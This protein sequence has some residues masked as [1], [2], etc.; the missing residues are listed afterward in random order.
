MTQL[1]GTAI[2]WCIFAAFVSHHLRAHVHVEA[3]ATHLEAPEEQ[4]GEEGT[5]DTP[6][7]WCGSHHSTINPDDVPIVGTMPPESEAKGTTGGDLIS[8]RTASVDKKP[9][10]TN[11]VDDY[12]QGEID[13]RWKPIRIRAYTQDL[14]DP[15]R[16][17]TMAGDVR[18]ILVSGKTTVCTAGDVLTVRKK[19]VIVQVAIPKAI[20]LHTDRLLVRR[21]HRRIVLPSSYA[22]Y[23]SLFK[24]P[25]GHY[26]N[27]FEGDVSI[28]VAA[29]PTIGNM[30][31]AS[32]CA[33][34]T[35]GRPVSGVVNIS[36]KY[37][38]ETDFF[39]R[40]IAHELGHALGF[41]ADILIRRGIMKQ[42]GGIRGLK[43]SWLVDS[44]VAK[45]V[46]R[47]HFN[48]STAPGIEMENEGG[49][50]VFATH[51]EQRNAVEDVM[52]PYG[53]LNYLTVMSLGVFASMG[54]Y[55]VNFSRAEKTRWG[56]N[57][58][59]SFLQE[60]CLQEGKSKHPDTF[61]DH[62]WKSRLFTCTHDRLGLGQCSLGTHRTELPAEFRY[63]RNSRVGGKSRFMDHCPM[64]VQYNSGNC[65]N[66]QSKFLR[67]SEVGKG[68]RC[69]KGVNL[70]FS[71]KDIG[72]VC[73]RTNCTGKELQ[74]RFLLDH[75]WQTCK[76]GAT[77]QPLGRHLWK[78]SIICP[79]R[80][81]VCFDDEDYKLRLTPLPKL[82]TDDNAAVN[83]RQM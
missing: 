2:F 79:T 21:Y 10:Y 27:G 81:E 38:A 77:V 42:K 3:S 83:P 57:R 18:S 28:Y 59:C 44:E 36:P 50:G 53:N 82:P 37:V 24:V 5:G 29:R 9:K 68:S 20:K 17:C 13:S 65:V 48:C 46:A 45:R 71:N 62:L 23:C 72:D 16:F 22:G 34:L 7:G 61:C 69:V 60:K 11:N 32:V 26:T 33:M 56:L 41:Q 43:T 64:V 67:G 14:N 70:K 25:K 73:V 30:A 52:A 12:G 49:P 39:V 55:R 31:W 19:R 8:A 54:H 40:V 58:G 6:R 4:W 76:P 80:E 35:D 63:F 78:G 66:G 51:L 1:L 74:I 47:K 75:S 15:S